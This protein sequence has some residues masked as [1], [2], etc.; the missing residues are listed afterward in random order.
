MGEL[1]EFLA[2][3]EDANP[4]GV[5]LRNDARFH[6]LERTLE[7]AARSA[8]VTGDVASPRTP[9]IDW[10]GLLKDAG[11]MARS[12]RDLR[13]LVMVV[14]MATHQRGLEGLAEGLGLLT[15]TVERYWDN[16]HP[17]L[18]DSPSRREAALRR[19]NALY[20]L[21]NTDNG[22]M[23]D[24][25][26]NPVFTLRGIGPVTGGDLAAAAMSRV[27]ILAEAADGLG[28]KEKAALAAAHETQMARVTAALKA[29]ATE[30][31]EECA[32]LA[33]AADRAKAALVALEAALEAR[34]AENGLGV[35]FTALGTL[36]TRI[37]QSLATAEA[38]PAE[39]SA[40]QPMAAALPLA[41]TPV[42]GAGSVPGQIT[43]RREVERCLDL[44]ID[45]Y[46]RTEPSS[47]L[48]H[49]AR[50]MRKMVPMTFMQLMEEIAPSGMKEFRAV[51]GVIDEKSK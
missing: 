30:R 4:S 51:A 22:L 47:P 13:L 8:R 31:P 14:R 10:D 42:A 46:E 21:E 33:A 23:T 1:E 29:L 39:S 17:A 15:A 38:A 28:E 19:I 50:R 40:P 16:L 7:P 36:V 49:L 48:P 24:L 27:A 35:R 34:V 32:A 37:G 43:S 45:F 2:P 20:Q 25:A 9:P 11:S 5:E 41:A 12:G 6:A 26:L 18:R 44:I 3:V